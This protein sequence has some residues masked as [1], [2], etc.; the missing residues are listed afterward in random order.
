MLN[1]KPTR[2]PPN[3]NKSSR[4]LS[5]TQISICEI[6]YHEESAVARFAGSRWFFAAAYGLDRPTTRKDKENQKE[7]EREREYNRQANRLRESRGAD[8]I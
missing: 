3:G 5:E 1:T 4:A 2:I 8:E 6:G 7:R